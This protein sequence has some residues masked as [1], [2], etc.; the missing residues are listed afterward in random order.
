MFFLKKKN[1]AWSIPNWHKSKERK[2]ADV[3]AFG[4]QLRIYEGFI[5]LNGSLN[6]YERWEAF[7]H[8]NNFDPHL[9]PKPQAQPPITPSHFPTNTLLPSDPCNKMSIMN[10]VWHFLTFHELITLQIIKHVHIC[11]KRRQNGC[12]QLWLMTSWRLIWW[13]SLPS[14]SPPPVPSHP[15]LHIESGCYWFIIITPSALFIRSHQW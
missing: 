10:T 7:S 1:L 11:N 3:I 2:P 13:V 14:T 5:F 15:Q 12:Q 4:K 8:L 9:S 6:F